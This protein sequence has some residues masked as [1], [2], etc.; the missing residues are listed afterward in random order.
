MSLQENLLYMINEINN[1]PYKD[2][3]GREYH[4]TLSDLYKGYIWKNIDLKERITLGTMFY[5]WAL[6]EGKEIVKPDGKTAQGQQ[7]YGRL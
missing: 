6:N 4:F 5:D 7:L 2:N 3:K 1:V